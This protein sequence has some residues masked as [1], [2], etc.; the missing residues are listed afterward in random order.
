MPSKRTKRRAA[1]AK[2]TFEESKAKKAKTL[3]N[4]IHDTLSGK[5]G[6]D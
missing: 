4:D 3:A 6:L 5:P 2:K 1:H